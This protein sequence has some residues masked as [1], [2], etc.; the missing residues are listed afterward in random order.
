MSPLC[1]ASTALW[2]PAPLALPRVVEVDKHHAASRDP[3]HAL[4]PRRP[5]VERSPA[6]RWEAAPDVCLSSRREAGEG[7]LKS[8]GDTLNTCTEA[9]RQRL[10]LVRGRAHGPVREELLL[11]QRRDPGRLLWKSQDVKVTCTRFAL[12][13]LGSHGVFCVG[14][15]PDRGGRLSSP[16][17]TV[18]IWG[19]GWA[20]HYQ[21][22]TFTNCNSRS[23]RGPAQPAKR[24]RGGGVTSQP[25]P[26]GLC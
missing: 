18:N 3:H 10:P 12:S 13:A 8:E 21:G 5:A 11:R 20:P 9:E 23:V 14:A 25:R 1:G 2:A 26:Q 17:M 6:R 22:E 24:S 19:L 16:G 7:R 4:L 15:L